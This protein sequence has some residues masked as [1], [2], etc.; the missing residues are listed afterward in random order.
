LGRAIVGFYG[1]GLVGICLACLLAGCAGNPRGGSAAGGAGGWEGRTIVQTASGP[2]RGHPDRLGTIAWKGLPYAAPPV[3]ELRW[4]AP[5]DPLPWRDLRDAGRFGNPALQQAP[6]VGAVFG[7]E[8]CLYL[9]VWRSA[10]GGTGLPVY[11]F[12]HGGGNST[13]SANLV[14]D[15]LGWAVAARSGM[16]FVSMN[17]RL[18]PLGWFLDPAVTGAAGALDDSASGNF[19]TLDIIKALEWVRRNIAAFGGDPERVTVA[20]ESAGAFNVLSLLL[21]PRASGL[22]QRAVSESGAQNAVTRGVAEAASADLIAAWFM[23]TGRAK[24]REGALAAA[25]AIAPADLASLLRKADARTL[26]G[27]RK[28]GVTGMTGWPTI[29]SDGRVIPESGF[30]AFKDGSWPN[31]VPL[32]LGSNK[33]ETKLFLYFDR[34][35]DWKG[36]PYEEAAKYGS[37]SWKANGVDEIAD[38]IAGADAAAGSPP[39]FVYRFDWGAPGMDGASILPGNWGRRLGAF[40]SLEVSFF[41]GTGSCLGPLFTGRLFTAANRPGREALSAACMRYLAAFAASGDPNP[42]GG[43]LPYWPPRPSRAA[44]A[45]AG[46]RAVGLVL[47]ATKEG[48][49]ISPLTEVVTRQGVLDAI[50]SGLEPA[51]AAEV[52]ARLLIR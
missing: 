36:R 27:L 42:A 26:V 4:K 22:F 18:G 31:K 10:G 41:L 15:Y 43:G 40:H 49:R 51:L 23:K 14:N 33:E 16:V 3:G 25:R 2:V 50:D 28:G 45:A 34:K 24:T 46:G 5:Q 44:Q 47:D 7:S 38:S 8:D 39:V 35:L 30:G 1:I 32:L 19:G 29:I 12:I 48:L 21:S 17:Y 52:R 6:F 37:L 9:N 13:G 20:G 11:V